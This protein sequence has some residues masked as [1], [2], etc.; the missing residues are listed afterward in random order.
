MLLKSIIIGFY[1]HVSIIILLFILMVIVKHPQNT[2]RLHPKIEIIYE[3]RFHVAGQVFPE[4]T[5]NNRVIS[6]YFYSKLLP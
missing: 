1:C 4:I 5:S 3:H 6:S 2:R